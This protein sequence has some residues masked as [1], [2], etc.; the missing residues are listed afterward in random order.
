MIIYH[1]L[2]QTI[3]PQYSLTILAGFILLFLVQNINVYGG[4]ESTELPHVNDTNLQ[5]EEYA[6]GFWFPTGMNFLGHDDILVLEKN[7]GK[8]KEIKNGTVAKTILD[9][10]VANVSERGL[11]GIA[12][13]DEPRYVFLFYT[14]T[15]DMDG[16]DV[17]GNRLYRYEYDNGKLTT[18]NYS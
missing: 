1:I 4:T 14:E 11:L 13:S 3:T 2:L 17:L 16:G 9:V 10:N 5:I 8:V 7:S 12:V 15:E 6:S 18:R